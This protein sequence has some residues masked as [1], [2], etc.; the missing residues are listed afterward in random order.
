LIP[1]VIPTF[2]K[3]HVKDA[4]VKFL[5]KKLDDDIIKEFETKFAE[6]INSKHAISFPYARAGLYTFLKSQNLDRSNIILPAY[7]CIVVPNAILQSSNNPVFV[8]NA[9]N[10]VNMDID[11]LIKTVDG[12]TKAVIVTHMHGYSTDI[13]RIKDELPKD[14]L[15]IEDSCLS[16]LSTFEKKSTG[17]KGDISL[18]SFNNTKQITTN[19]GGMVVTN[20]EEIAEK[21]RKTRDKLF[22]K[23]STL[24][25]INNFLSANLTNQI[26]EHD[27]LFNLVY[28]LW[29]HY[30]FVKKFTKPADINEVS[31]DS[32]FFVQFDAIRAYLGLLRLD[33]LDYMI[34]KRKKIAKRYYE[35]LETIENLNYQEFDS[36]ATYGHFPVWSKDR[37]LIKNKLRKMG[38]MTGHSFDYSCPYTPAYENL[39]SSREYPES[40]KLSDGI[41]NLPMHHKLSNHEVEFI[42]ECIK[43]ISTEI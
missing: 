30:G 37:S 42:C 3:K 1:C 36:G 39:R 2:E 4:L 25:F 8:D 14:V 32:D 11:R 7:Q 28:Y 29:Y 19:N 17:N 15:I 24:K 35:T 43:K 13:E 38:I 41:F 23:P 6:K 40:K 33:D 22:Q 26:Y 21:I 27:K 34:T 31:Y 20:S 16:I 18:Y 5:K 10:Q 12:K 9:K